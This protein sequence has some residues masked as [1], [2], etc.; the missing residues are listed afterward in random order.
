VSLKTYGL[1][2]QAKHLN[3]S[4]SRNMVGALNAGNSLL[5]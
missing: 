3:T 1:S 5:P 4:L 2:I